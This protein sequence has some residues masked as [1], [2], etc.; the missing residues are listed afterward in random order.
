[1]KKSLSL[2]LAVILVCNFFCIVSLKVRA[3]DSNSYILDATIRDFDP[4]NNEHP[5]RNHPDFENEAYFDTSTTGA[6]KAVLGADGTPVYAD[7]GFS[8]KIITSEE[9]FYDWYHDTPKNVNIPYSMVFNKSGEDY[10]FDSTLTDGF[11]PINNMGFGN[12]QDNKNYHFTLELH[13]KFVY[14]PG[15]VF[16]I[17][18]D[19]DLWL[20]VN[21]KIVGDMGGIHKTQ[22]MTVNLDDHAMDL[23]LVPDGVYALDVFFAER[24]VT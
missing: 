9:S 3:E 22:D 4:V 8:Q 23:G 11:F 6:V 21:G 14:K 19:D 12:Y 1:M 2:L 20:F 16:S 10:I 13:A 7:S 15:Q 17:A 5:E 18:G 24:H